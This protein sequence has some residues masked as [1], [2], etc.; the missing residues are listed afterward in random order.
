LHRC[1]GRRE[2]PRWQF[3]EEVAPCNFDVRAM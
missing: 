1:G 3:R 2:N